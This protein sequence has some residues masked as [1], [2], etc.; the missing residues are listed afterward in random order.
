MPTYKLYRVFCGKISIFREKLFGVPYARLNLTHAFYDLTS[1]PTFRSPLNFSRGL[2]GILYGST[3]FLRPSIPSSPLS[4]QVRLIYAPI[5]KK[6]YA[7]NYRR[8]IWLE[9]VL[10]FCGWVAKKRSFSGLNSIF[11]VSAPLR[12]EK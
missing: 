1:H 3:L 4:R 10:F 5:I 12:F 2:T 7:E 11:A 9:S 6:V 8:V